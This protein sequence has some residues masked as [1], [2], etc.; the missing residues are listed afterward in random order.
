MADLYPRPELYDVP[1]RTDEFNGMPFRYVGRSGLQAAAIGLGTWKFGYP[2][3]GDGSR[4]GP[5]TTHHIL[6]RALELGVTFW[7]TA[8]RYNAASGNSERLIGRWLAANPDQ[9]RNVIVATKVFGG[10]D[11]ISPNHSGLS[12]TNI[13]DGLTACL[14]RLQLD[15]V[16]LLWFHRFDEAV[17]IEESLETI[18]DLVRQGLI[19]YFG[20]SNHT[21]EQLEAILE[22]QRGISHRCRPVAV[23]NQFDPLNGEKEGFGGVLEFCRREDIAF[24]PYSPLAKGMLTS[25]Y[26]DV[27]RSGPGDRLYDEGALDEPDLDTKLGT[28]RRLAELAR[29]LDAEISQLVLAYLLTL[30]GMGPQ[31]PSSSTVEQLESNAAAARI[32]LSDEQIAAVREVFG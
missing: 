10:M 6:D 2:D 13:I 30:P 12:R 29:D 21:V 25:R 4:V 19:R 14:D 23:Q 31:I 27:G 16:D 1:F 7:D 24:V 28:V 20:V 26:L 18:D 8:N 9:R 22:V 17:P 15:H 5:R 3:T 32:A 11:G